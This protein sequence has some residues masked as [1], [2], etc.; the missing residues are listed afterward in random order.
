M[1]VARDRMTEIEYLFCLKLPASSCTLNVEYML[2]VGNLHDF[3]DVLCI[4]NSVIISMTQNEIDT[5]V[6]FLVRTCLF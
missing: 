1:F 3:D 5:S 6:T 4:N 2:S